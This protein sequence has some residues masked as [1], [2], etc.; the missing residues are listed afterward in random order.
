MEGRIFITFLLMVLYCSLFADT[1]ANEKKGFMEFRPA[2]VFGASYFIW[3]GGG[4]LRAGTQITE[5]PFK[6][7]VLAE[8]ANHTHGTKYDWW[9]PECEISM[10]LKLANLM[11]ITPP[12]S[13]YLQ[14]FM[15]IGGGIGNYKF[16]SEVYGFE[17][18]KSDFLWCVGGG[19]KWTILT[20]GIKYYGAKISFYEEYRNIIET[21]DEF[22]K[23]HFEINGGTL[24]TIGL[25]F[26]Y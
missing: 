12:S 13:W 6:I 24:I 14:A 8:Y 22:N 19:I 5:K 1:T 3:V 26:Y 23:E 4:S 10:S 20:I 2:L 18:E 7:S 15:T 21:N 25:L 9:T 11:I 17:S 16:E